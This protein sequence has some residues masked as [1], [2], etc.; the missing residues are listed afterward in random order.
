MVRG[1]RGK[2]AERGDGGWGR[3]EEGGGKGEEGGGRREEGCG[4][5]E[6]GGGRREV[7]GGRR[8][9]A[10]GRREEGGGRGEEGRGVA[11][12]Y[13]ACSPTAMSP[14]RIRPRSLSCDGSVTVSWHENPRFRGLHSSTS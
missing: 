6:E 4:L 10:G 9:E 5:R 7:G 12:T 14:P 13:P 8:E 1:I 2:G 11:S 3:R